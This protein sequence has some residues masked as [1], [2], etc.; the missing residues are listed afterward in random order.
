MKS[1]RGKSDGTYDEGFEPDRSRYSCAPSYSLPGIERPL[2]DLD[3]AVEHLKNRK[4]VDGKRMI[5]GGQSRG[6]ILP[7]LGKAAAANEG[8]RL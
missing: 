4:D 8:C 7:R 6:G 1:G 3:A 2:K 5:I